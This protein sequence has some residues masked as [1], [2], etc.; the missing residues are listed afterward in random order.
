MLA[1]RWLPPLGVAGLLTLVG[2]CAV[3][4][5]ADWNTLKSEN[6]AL[7]EENRAIAARL[8]N[9]EIHGR[10]TQDQ[11]IQAEEDLAALDEQH[12]LSRKQ[13]ANYRFQQQQLNA[14]FQGA[15]GRRWPISPET[16][17]RLA[18]LSRKYP[19]L[20]LDPETGIAKLNTDIL[21]DLGTADLKPAAEEALGQLAA[22]LKTPEAEDLKLLV[23]GHTDD[24]PVARKPARDKFRNNFD[25]S[26]E[27]AVAV[28]EYLDRLGLAEQRMGVAGF[29][30][31]QPVAPNITPADRRKNRRV[32]L[33]VLAPDVPVVGWTET[34]PTV[35]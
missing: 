28:C 12:G 25:L 14:R 26:A 17:R 9:L 1:V 4:P 30:A 32:E 22:A 31:H 16:G 18:E 7:L 2:G 24:R 34:I 35:Y 6:A 20:Q 15:T 21:F 5:S 11:L 10:N 27:R 13:L 8:R 23:V 33:F 19:Q 29:G 3:V